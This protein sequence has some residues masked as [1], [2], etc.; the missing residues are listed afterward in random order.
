MAL[1]KPRMMLD[2]GRAPGRLPGTQAL[3][4]PRKD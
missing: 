1:D 3:P 2:S 4:A